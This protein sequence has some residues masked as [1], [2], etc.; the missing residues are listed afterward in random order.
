MSSCDW[1]FAH[2]ISYPCPP[3][4]QLSLSAVTMQASS[5]RIRGTS[6]A[7]HLGSY[8]A[9]S[10]FDYA[11]KRVIPL[12]AVVFERDGEMIGYAVHSINCLPWNRLKS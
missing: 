9:S 11:D 10:I 6:R 8:P 4:S 7:V 12:E 2:P 5:S 3:P 1:C